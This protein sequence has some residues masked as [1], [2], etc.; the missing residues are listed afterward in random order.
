MITNDDLR[1][2][3]RLQTERQDHERLMNALT[4]AT[5]VVNAV[6]H[7]ESWQERTDEEQAAYDAALDLIQE[8]ARQFRPRRRHP[9]CE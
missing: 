6:G 3:L 9:E 1:L 5:V 7:R 4:A 2:A 8:C